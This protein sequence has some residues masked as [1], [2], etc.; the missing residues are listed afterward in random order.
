[1]EQF[2]PTLLANLGDEAKLYVAD[3]AS[4]DLSIEWLHNNYPAVEIIQNGSNLGFAQGY[5]KALKHLPEPYLLLLNSDVEVTSGWLNPLVKA[6]DMNPLL[7]AC[8]PKIRWEREKQKFEYSGAAGGFIDWLGYPFCRGRV[9]DHLEVDTGQYDLPAEI[10]WASGACMMVRSEVFKQTGG[11]D[12]H[13]FAHME[14][15]DLCWRIRNLGFSIQC[16]P[17]STVYH[18]GGATLPKNNSRK[19]FLNFR[20]NLSALWKNL[21]IY[22]LPIVIL[23]RLVLDG[24]AGIKFLT[25]GHV[26]DFGAVIA[27]HFAFYGSIMSGK[28]KRPLGSKI[29]HGTIYK[30]SVVWQYYILGRKKFSDLKF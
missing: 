2:V 18:V 25:E 19:T 4:S 30:G 15:I 14:E 5:N 6:M 23:I 3:N 1:L 20:N 9:F 16:I 26:K 13:F 24:V 29:K 17:S 10:F 21:P 28:L 7:G 12:A 27:A 8:Q 11:F 22:Q